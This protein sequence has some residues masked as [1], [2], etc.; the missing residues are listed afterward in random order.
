[1]IDSKLQR[2]LNS[3]IENT[4]V[5]EQKMKEDI[6][7]LLSNNASQ[8]PK[9]YVTKKIKPYNTTRIKSRN[10][11]GNTSY[12]KAKEEDLF[13]RSFVFDVYILMII[14]TITHSHSNEKFLM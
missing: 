5:E 11:F 13:D 14:K 6:D 1:M 3:L 8:P 4:L 12:N 7:F 10:I 2:N 9:K